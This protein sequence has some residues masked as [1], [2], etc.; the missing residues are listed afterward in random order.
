[1]WCACGHGDLL[2]I[3]RKFFAAPDPRDARR[4]GIQAPKSRRQ[5]G[6]PQ[7]QNCA[8]GTQ[9][10]RNPLQAWQRS[11]ELPQALLESP[12]WQV[13]ELSQHPLEQEDELQAALAG[14]QVLL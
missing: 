8:R 12:L 2:A 6:V 11:P 3:A 1:M 5:I 7:K 9:K 4:G 10:D 14:K 13:P